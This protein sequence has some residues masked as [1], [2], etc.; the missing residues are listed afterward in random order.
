MMYNMQGGAVPLISLH[1]MLLINKRHHDI[2]ERSKQLE[3]ARSI[4]D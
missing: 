3:S 4:K 2:E 1:A